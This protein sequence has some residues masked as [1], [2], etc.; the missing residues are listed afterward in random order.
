MNLFKMIFSTL[1]LIAAATTAHAQVFIGGNPKAA[2][3]IEGCKTDRPRSQRL[4]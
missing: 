4:S 1:A 3:T 2:L